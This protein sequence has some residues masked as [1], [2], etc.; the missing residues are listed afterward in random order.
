MTTNPAS[1]P[2]LVVVGASAGGIDALSRL[3]ATLPTDFPAPIVIAQHLQPSRE[4]HLEEI[5]ARR[6]K[7][8]VRTVNDQEKIEPGVI[9]VI[10][11]NRD[12]EITDHTITVLRDQ[13][14]RPKPSIDRLLESAAHIFGERLIAVILTGTGSDGAEGARRVKEVGG[15][16]IVQNPET[17]QYP[18]LPRSLA[19]STV[20]IV[21]DLD[22]IG[23]LLRD[24]L[25]GAYTPSNP[26][27]E[28]QLQSLLDQVRG[29]SGIDFSRYRQPT[30]R[31]R[32][33][34]RMADTGQD[35]V[36]QYSQYLRRHPEEYERLVSSFLIKVTDFF[37]DPELFDYIG[38]R[39]LPD[40]IDDARSRGNELRIW[41]AGCAT[42]EEA[43][44]LA[45]LFADVL[46]PEL[47]DFSI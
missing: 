44:S 45:I 3:V 24:L 40:L 16:V 8:P 31:R 20:D 32:L 47:E 22:A 1:G 37:R 35:T 28:R 6:T 21:S 42:G 39:L 33:Q 7:L 36:E 10:P 4:S 14:G 41:S 2:D 34:R 18:E 23:P 12:V 11:A 26:D 38:Q 17:A 9:Y 27:E 25:T 46:G 30:I 13:P 29:R 15:T 43:Y 19:P 5:L